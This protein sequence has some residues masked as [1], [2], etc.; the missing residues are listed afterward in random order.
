MGEAVLVVLIIVL[1]VALAVLI[2]HLPVDQVVMVKNGIQ[3][4]GQAEEAAADQ[5]IM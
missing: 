5:A 3:H 1:A 4:M 2:L